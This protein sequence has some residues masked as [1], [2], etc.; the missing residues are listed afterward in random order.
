[1]SRPGSPT[2]TT[3]KL[4]I[5]GKTYPLRDQLRALG[6]EFVG[7]ERAWFVSTER[8]EAVEALG[9]SVVASAPPRPESLLVSGRGTYDVRLD[10][11][12]LGGRWQS[13]ISSWVLPIT[14]RAEAE[15]LVQGRDVTLREAV[16][17]APRRAQPA[18]RTERP[19]R[20][21]PEVSGEAAQR[22]AVLEAERQDLRTRSHAL[23][24]QI[25]ELKRTG[26]ADEARRLQAV[27]DPLI[28][29]L[30]TMSEESQ[31]LREG[32]TNGE[33][34]QAARPAE[35]TPEQATRERE[36]AS[37][38]TPPPAASTPL[39]AAAEEHLPGRQSGD[40]PTAVPPAAP[41]ATEQAP[42]APTVTPAPPSVLSPSADVGGG[43]VVLP[44][45]AQHAADLE[46]YREL[47][48]VARTQEELARLDA[49]DQK[50]G[51]DI[52]DP[53][54]TTG[55]SV[56]GLLPASLRAQLP[57]I[58]AQE[59]LGP[60]AVAHVKFFLG[61][62]TWYVTEF[63]GKDE[64]FGLVDGHEKE[65]GYFSL[66][67][68]E[69]LRGPFGL[70]VE[71]D[72]YWTP[73]TLREIAPGKFRD[74]AFTVPSPI[75]PP[76]PVSPAAEIDAISDSPY[77]G[78]DIPALVEAA[79]QEQS[80][81][82]LDLAALEAALASLT[83]GTPREVQARAER[84]RLR[85]RV[86]AAYEEVSRAA[87]P[88]AAA[89]LR[90]ELETASQADEFDPDQV[91]AE[92]LAAEPPAS[93]P[94]DALVEAAPELADGA[95]VV[96][97]GMARLIDLIG[98][99]ITHDQARLAMGHGP[100]PDWGETRHLLD[101][102]A[103]AYGG[104]LAEGKFTIKD[105]Y[106]ALEAAVNI[107]VERRV[108]DYLVAGFAPE[109]TLGLLQRVQDRLP[110]QA[111]RTREQQLHQQ[112]STPPTLAFAAVRAAGIRPDDVVLEP[113]AGV[114]SL[115]VLARAE[116]ATVQTNEIAPRRQALLRHQGFATTAVDAEYLHDL[117]PDEGVKPTVIVMN[118]PFSANGGRTG[119][120]S[121][122][123]M[124]HVLQAL[125]R[126]EPGGRLVAITGQTMTF[127]TSEGPSRAREASGAASRDWWVKVMDRYTVRAN[128]AMP[129]SVYAK[130]GTTYGTQLLVIDKTGPTPGSTWAERLGGIAWGKAG[131]LTE[132]LARV[133]QLRATRGAAP[134]PELVAP[135]ALEAPAVEKAAP[136]AE[137]PSRAA[138]A[139]GIP[140]PS[141][142]SVAG[143]G[144][145]Q[146]L[147]RE[148]LAPTRWA[149]RGFDGHWLTATL[150]GQAVHGSG[151]FW[152]LGAPPTTRT[153][154][155]QAD[156]ALASA[157]VEI[158]SLSGRPGPAVTVAALSLDEHRREVAWMSNGFPVDARQLDYVRHLHRG[159]T[160]HLE[161]DGLQARDEQGSW[162]GYVPRLDLAP[163]PPAGVR[164]IL[165]DGLPPQRDEIDAAVLFVTRGLETDVARTRAALRM[166][167][168]D[169]LASAG[170]KAGQQPFLVDDG[171]AR[172]RPVRV[173]IDSQALKL[174]VN[175]PRTAAPTLSANA[176]VAQVVRLRELEIVK[177]LRDTEVPAAEVEAAPA[178][179]KRGQ[180]K[181][182]PKPE[183]DE[184]AIKE[185]VAFPADGLSELGSLQ[186]GEVR[187]LLSGPRVGG[188][189]LTGELS[190]GRAWHSNGAFLLVAP[191]PEL[192]Y[193][194]Q[195]DDR[196]NA[197]SAERVEGVLN[198]AVQ[199][200]LSVVHPVALS[201]AP[202]GP[203]L[204]WLSDG[205]PYESRMLQYVARAVPGATFV[206]GAQPGAPLAVRDESG[207]YVAVVNHWQTPAAPAGVERLLA[208]A[209]Q[210]E[211]PSAPRA[212]QVLLAPA[213]PQALSAQALATWIRTRLIEA[214]ER[215]PG[216]LSTGAE[217]EPGLVVS[218]RLEPG[219]RL[220]VNEGGSLREPALLEMA[221]SALSI[222]LAAPH[223]AEELE[224]AEPDLEEALEG[225]AEDPETEQALEE[226]S[227]VE[228]VETAPGRPRVPLLERE[229]A[230]APRPRAVA[231]VRA[232]DDAVFVDYAPVRLDTTGLRAHP[233]RLVETASMAAVEPPAIT[234]ASSL[235][236]SLL[237]EGRLS[238]VQY[239]AIL[240]AGQAHA[241]RMSEGQ[242]KAFFTGAGT[243]V[244]KGRVLSGVV[245][246]N[247]MQGR[248]RALWVSVSNDLIE[249]T[250]RD[251][252]DLDA[253]DDILLARL[254]DFGPHESIEQDR[255]VI[256]CT[257]ATLIQ[258][259]K[260]TGQTRVD[261]LKAWLGDDGVMIFDEAHKAKNA[262][263]SGRGEA[264]QTAQAVLKL[265]ELLPGAR[266]VYSSATGATDVR[267][268]A[269]M[270]RLGLWGPG[271]SFSGGF[272]EFLS[273][274]DAG[275]VGAM[276][277]V[278]RDLKALGL[279]WAPS[280]SFQ[281]VE[282]REVIHSLTAEQRAMYDTACAAWQV[283]LADVN[284]ALGDTGADRTAK[285]NAMT[286]FW[287]AE[288]RFFKQVLT[289]MKVPTVIR[290]TQEALDRGQSVVIGL[291]GTGEARTEG[292]VN[293][294]LAEGMELDDLDFTPREILA[295]F[296]D[297][298]F[299]TEL[300][301]E[302]YN[303]ET[304]ETSVRKV[305][306]AN[307]NPV[308][309]K[310]ALAAKQALME[311][312]SGGLVLPE[313]PLD[314]MVNHF[315]VDHVA[316]LT[317]RH[318]RLVR[319]P[320]TGRVEYVKRAPDGVAM[321]RVNLWEMDQFQSGVK[322]IAVISQAASTGISLHASNRDPNQ[323]RRCHI[324]A[325][326]G[327]SADQ[328][329]QT[330][331]RTHRSDQA[332]AP[333]YRLV[334]SDVG[335]EKR[336][337]STIA[338]RLESLG[339]LTKGQAD[340][341]GQGGLIEYN[342]ETDEGKA[343]LTALYRRM[344]RYGAGDDG[345]ENPRQVLKDMGILR[346]DGHKESIADEDYDHV[347]R[348]LNRLLAIDVARQNAVFDAYARIYESVVA[349][350]R[351]NGTFDR[352]VTDLH[353]D[354][355][356]LAEPPA[357]VNRDETTGAATYHYVV[358]MERKVYPIRFESL[359]S[360]GKGGFFENTKSGRVVYAE[361]GPPKTDELSGR[362]TERKALTTARARH[363]EY[364][365][366][367]KFEADYR[368]L[369]PDEAKARWAEAVASVPEKATERAH[370]I[371][372]AILPLWE[373]LKS[374]N[375]Q[376]LHI[377]RAALAD[378]QRVVGIRIPGQSVARILAAIGIKQSLRTPEE[379]YRGVLE[380]RERVELVGGLRVVHSM[381][382]YESRIELVGA[383][384]ARYRELRAMGLKEE[385]D[386]FKYRFYVPTDEVAGI[387]VLEKLLA[388][389]PAL[390][391]EPGVAESTKRPPI[392]VV[393]PLQQGAE[394][395]P[396]I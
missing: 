158:T 188:A 316:E 75:E 286:A 325:E 91:L 359:A 146:A 160:W 20:A 360:D 385:L 12:A 314:Q 223:L 254:N 181:A 230:P 329:L 209:R 382:Y 132:A 251:L 245:I 239:E 14:A 256:F 249:A 242:R 292:K 151:G 317:G 79:R 271:T 393:V 125:Q 322:R 212:L 76:V 390:A 299:P 295:Q 389:Y 70:P 92:D 225:L 372:G 18:Q 394:P 167:L 283:V 377:V 338:R 291:I 278:A 369:D 175:T 190:D 6:A 67:E 346:V 218:A 375:A 128:L 243:G 29:R 51:G 49:L 300:Y 380:A 124:S 215:H 253:G 363:A 30:I 78:D 172:V 81:R 358:E 150:A 68:L 108:R 59:K 396:A 280:I 26:Q 330:F 48:T 208:A 258:K 109:D 244:G 235:P 11:A 64:L 332:S 381:K 289:A 89:A 213:P 13:A 238:D 83:P 170:Q 47:A 106:D 186:R 139:V 155:Q 345:L 21:L 206:R 94:A 99:V 303:D 35:P 284:K 296:V 336:F 46:E 221:R 231:L 63:D 310:E 143:R 370:L 157:P 165:G 84:D 341:S 73:T 8:R 22:L 87:G 339:A 331:G 156:S 327:W 277:M 261:Q 354:A 202:D 25:A 15:R 54:D 233:G 216:L 196:A 293:K 173:E 356:R 85:A 308:Q 197:V 189:W 7:G 210:R 337:V 162:V 136:G 148:L 313:N 391:A 142:R 116:G 164:E 194:G 252:N 45:S 335:G 273:E 52:T 90:Q 36:E 227:A 183:I 350:A 28:K 178:R 247:W 24:D 287:G 169:V 119:N 264:T 166:T 270:S 53:R 309:S 32:L 4:R 266:V 361:D 349:K 131:S 50:Y 315:G 368:R 174:W 103:Q 344:E 246:D 234:Y 95:G 113:S 33:S 137:V 260:K 56:G 117:L 386:N 352:G 34:A 302:A 1:M 207:E 5:V 205:V 80:G 236:V 353:A 357:E 201:K 267:N 187:G 69:S 204:I 9:L 82:L 343:A 191:V 232:N 105:A 57:P 268:M 222:P 340:A 281:G 241:Q 135:P 312:L 44:I 365:D 257:Y 328:Q 195:K 355:V 55:R 203:E 163:A 40:Q 121:S 297:R 140:Y 279:Y 147:V 282:Y 347:P 255:G 177:P 263:P 141:E 374:T 10:L 373:R 220:K 31:A 60:A 378:G 298:A 276:E 96:D 168:A 392:N 37:T 395:I 2:P 43:A 348:F 27:R 305:L 179:A 122:I 114:G 62:W 376:R 127:G 134:T 199:A 285:R 311:K 153:A 71:R 237:E 152:A 224:A 307:G 123:G 366:R 66:A 248:Q 23:R 362:V 262:I 371:G 240:Y 288:Q 182:A 334:C 101:L 274:I 159:A 97:A 269:Y 180:P 351:E 144:P 120:D 320:G 130:Y 388:R 319:D 185:G 154:K 272:P 72:L 367:Y 250:R 229:I 214:A 107:Y 364:I 184:E 294:A 93:A 138:L 111:M 65:L 161:G 61:A 226:E 275:G 384:E 176:L 306:D 149:A 228:I 110:T 301:Q 102:A 318:R 304:G 211:V 88:S 342:F 326:L 133:E 259:S 265:Q 333:E 383:D 98:G 38:P 193:S 41:T 17:I 145:S 171:V 39:A 19:S 324:T 74:V 323:Q 126:L 321:A 192:R 58:G 100:S 217:V 129:G 77:V 118:P 115:A 219:L 379:V 104:T 290:E 112:F 3:T 42:E 86:D 16:V 200:P 387:E 198:S